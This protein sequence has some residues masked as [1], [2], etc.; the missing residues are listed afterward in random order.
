MIDGKQGQLQPCR[1]TELL[2]D[3]TQMMLHSVLGQFEVVSDLTIGEACLT[4]SPR[5]IQF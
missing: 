1:N 2:E 3:V 4:V 5:V